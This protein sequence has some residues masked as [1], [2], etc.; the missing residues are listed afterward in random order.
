MCNFCGKIHSIWFLLSVEKVPKMTNCSCVKYKTLHD[1]D[2][3]Y[4]LANV[5]VSR[6]VIF[7]EQSA[8][9]LK[10]PSFTVVL[11]P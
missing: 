11:F 2:F 3:V 10:T 9:S 4:S 1:S 7:E 5:S 8:E 6:L